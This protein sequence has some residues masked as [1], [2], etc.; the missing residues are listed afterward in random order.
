MRSEEGQGKGSGRLG[1]Q[2]TGPLV[3]IARD[4]QSVRSDDRQVLVRGPLVFHHVASLKGRSGEAL[5]ASGRV[6]SEE[7]SD[8]RRWL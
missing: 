4:G 2:A 6:P 1:R 3:W 7:R 8:T 5:V